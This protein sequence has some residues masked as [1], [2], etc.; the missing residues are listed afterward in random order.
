MA[1]WPVRPSESAIRSERTIATM[2]AVT[3][4]NATALMI[5][6]VQAVP[7]LLALALPAVA[8]AERLLPRRG[9]AVLAALARLAGTDA[10]VVELSGHPGN[11]VDP[12]RYRYAWDY[13]WGAEL[14]ALCSPAV[15]AAVDRHGFTLGTYR[16]LG[17]SAVGA[18]AT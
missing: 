7:A 17:R 12:D 10:A 15:R 2:S 11:A 5:V 8:L 4:T 3:T 16:D 13:R 1:R 14:D 9:P 6:I 18:G